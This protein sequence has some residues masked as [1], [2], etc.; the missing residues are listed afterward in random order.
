MNDIETAVEELLVRVGEQASEIGDRP[1]TLHWPLVGSGFDHGVLLVGQAVFG[2]FG[3]WTATD[4]VDPRRRQEIYRDARDLFAD[5]PDRMDWIEGNRVWNSPFWR[6]AREV[7]DAV[8][9]GRG[10]FYSRMA[11][12]N[13]YPVA[14][15]DVKSN[16]AG[17]LLKTQTKPAAMFL[18]AT[19]Q[20]LRP[21][22]VLVLGGP[23]VWPFLQLL[24][25]DNLAPVDRPL[26]L[27]G[28]QDGA[29][30]ILGMHPGGASR[31]GMG[32]ARYAELITRTWSSTS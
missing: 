3:D 32:P 30:W 20:A 15:N 5:R 10:P 16:P 7:T 19:I 26:Y 8:V 29:A 2:W 17:A 18:A 6:V 31:R 22:L 9:P 4:A 21:R 25:L 1:L 24:G 13:L 23:Y 27:R 12:A 14:P 28:R 11:W